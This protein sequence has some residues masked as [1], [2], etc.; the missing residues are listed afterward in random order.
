MEGTM[1]SAQEHTRMATVGAIAGAIIGGGI[2]F[3]A[4]GLASAIPTMVL[5]AVGGAVVGSFM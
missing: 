3:V 2:G 5:G 4:L 1:I